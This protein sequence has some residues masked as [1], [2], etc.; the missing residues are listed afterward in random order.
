MNYWTQSENNIFVAARRGFCAKYPENTMLAFKKAIELGVDQIETDIRITKDNQLVLIHDA[1]LDRTT[2][3]SGKV[4]DYTLDELK[5]LDA[6]NGEQIPTLRFGSSHGWLKVVV[7][8][9]LYLLFSFRSIGKSYPN[10]FTIY[11]L[12]HTIFP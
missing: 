7:F 11:Q 4:C 5:Q 1:T 6:G 8:V 3:G 9:F 2:N 10:L 12:R